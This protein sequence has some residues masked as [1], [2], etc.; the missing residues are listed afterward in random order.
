M[1]EEAIKKFRRDCVES[2]V[3]NT[4][5]NV[6]DTGNSLGGVSMREAAAYHLVDAAYDPGSV[7]YAIDSMGGAVEASHDLSEEEFAQATQ[8]DEEFI[9]TEVV[10]QLRQ[11]TG[12]PAAQD[13]LL[14]CCD[15]IEGLFDD[16]C[17]WP[18]MSELME[19][20]D[21]HLGQPSATSEG[22]G[23]E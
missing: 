13:L 8:W 6:I 14:R 18:E 11:M 4:V 23:D 1:S 19:D 3:G 10:D 17:P 20:I 5:D 15:V 21:K 22:E 12:H 9:K 2:L 16:A 7:A